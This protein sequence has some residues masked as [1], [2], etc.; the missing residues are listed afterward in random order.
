[1]WGTGDSDM[2]RYVPLCSMIFEVNNMASLATAVD[3][4]LTTR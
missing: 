4:L 2:L 3:R 1:M